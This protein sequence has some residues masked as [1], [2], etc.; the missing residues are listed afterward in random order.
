MSLPRVLV[1]CPTSDYKAYCL[2]DYADAVKQLSYPDYDILLVDNSETD[3]YAKEIT[4]QG[5]PVVRS[6]FH[7]GALQRIVESRNRLR[8][9]ALERGYG[10]LLSLEQDVIPPKDV[11]ERL[12]RLRKGIA[13]GI[14]F[15]RGQGRLIPLLG[16]DRGEEKFAYVPEELLAQVKGAMRVDYCGLGCVLIHHRVLQEIPFRVEEDK[17]GFDD[18][19][20]CVDAKSR[21]HDIF[22]LPDLTCKHLLKGRPW[23]WKEM[24]L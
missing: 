12:L 16:I 23:S 11:I 2:T 10:Y 13:T 22:A 18:W 6:P 15:N 17:A 3:G 9:E 14:Y 20:F 19:W 1:G 24:R 7:P 8:Q 4:K 5:L 21:G